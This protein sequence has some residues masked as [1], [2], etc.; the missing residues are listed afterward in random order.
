MHDEPEGYAVLNPL[1][2]TL[3]LVYEVEGTLA[4]RNGRVEWETYVAA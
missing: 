2:T 4:D 3:A 1:S